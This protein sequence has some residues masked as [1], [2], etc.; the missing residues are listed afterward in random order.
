VVV[1]GK[2]VVFQTLPDEHLHGYLQKIAG[3]RAAD[4][5]VEMYK[6]IR[7]VGCESSHHPKQE[8]PPLTPRRICA[9]YGGNPLEASNAHLPRPARTFQQAL[10]ARTDLV[11]KVFGSAE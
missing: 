4:C 1:S 10:E 7:E 5:L 8:K 2:N 6:G 3:D 9:D 11:H